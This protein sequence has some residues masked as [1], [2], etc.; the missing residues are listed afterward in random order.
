MKLKFLLVFSLVLLM[1]LNI[2]CSN[3][4]DETVLKLEKRPERNKHLFDYANK[5]QDVKEF[6][7][8]YLEMLER[9]YNIEVLIVTLPQLN[10]GFDIETQAVDLFNDWEVGRNN[11]GQGV[12]IL[13]SE[14]EKQ[15]KIEVGYELERIFTDAF[16]SYASDLQLKRYFISNNSLGLI[17]VLEEL[18]KRASVNKNNELVRDKIKKLDQ[19]FL[20][21]GAGIK[22]ELA[23]YKVEEIN[24][25]G[26]EDYSAALT[27]EEAWKRMVKS[28]R[29]KIR[30]PNLGIY[31]EA[32]KIVYNQPRIR[33]ASD[34]QFEEY[35]REYGDK[36]YEVLEKGNYAV[37]YFGKKKGWDNAP[38]FFCKTEEGWKFDVSNQARYVVM[39]SNAYW[40]VERGGNPYMR[41]LSMKPLFY[42]DN[43]DIPTEGRE[44]YRISQ[45]KIIASK[46]KRL[47]KEV[48]QGATDVNTL[49]ELGKSYSLIS[50]NIKAI[51]MLKKAIR[52]DAEY[53]PIYKYLAI[54]NVE[55]SFQYQTAIKY[56]KKYIELEPNDEF[57]YK[58]LGYLYYQIGEYR[59]AVYELN[60]RLELSAGDTYT[61]CKLARVYANLFK[62]AS[63]LNKN[64]YKRLSIRM[65]DKA[66]EDVINY[67]VWRV[68]A[69]E[70]YL[71]N[72]D[73]R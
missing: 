59:K 2:G 58:F 56:M 1:A 48:K 22:R 41:V 67:E 14:Q 28:W 18:E 71:R 36:E 4:L 49:F 38:F 35:I 25:I 61:Y 32:T 31:T 47:E 13:F 19:E 46:I 57:G 3:R 7:E 39:G 37:I 16:C 42:Y 52:L 10:E 15:I 60:Q 30:N 54:A 29:N 63:I 44:I 20:S 11:N 51:S 17:A 43:K 40:G 33:N 62:E 8:R 6:T 64:K 65:L 70:K 34:S 45:D 69:V 73:I 21:G 27:P 72:K 5:F 53:A 68:D 9:E 66:S 55:M 23:N 24:N 12:L 26:E 50:M